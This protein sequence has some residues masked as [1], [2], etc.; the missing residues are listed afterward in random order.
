MIKIS[1][2]DYPNMSKD[3]LYIEYCK[4]YN[5]YEKLVKREIERLETEINKAKIELQ[6][7]YIQSQCQN[8]CNK[9]KGILM[10]FSDFVEVVL[11]TPIC[12]ELKQ[13][14]DKWYEFYAKNPEKRLFYLKSTRGSTKK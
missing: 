12:Y 5:E 13:H 9:K 6:L 2:T 8:N 4:L 11:E 1:E 7:S 3:D 10:I 14:L